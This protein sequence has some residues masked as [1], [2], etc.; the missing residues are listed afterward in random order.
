MP[1]SKHSISM[2]KLLQQQ[3]DDSLG[4]WR[5]SAMPQLPRHGWAAVVRDALGMST[6]A[7]ARRLGMTRA[8]AAK[9]E[10]AERNRTITLGSLDRLANALECD[11]QYVFV[12][13]KPLAQ[14]RLEQARLVAT[15][16]LAPVSHTMALEQQAVST[17][18][19]AAQIDVAAQE[20]LTGSSRALWE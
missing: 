5:T 7:L 19:T 11:V 15:R 1:M 13:R 18:R 14:I 6:A 16:E 2:Q 17:Q 8:S 20:L 12:P 9:L 10:L 4:R 3:L